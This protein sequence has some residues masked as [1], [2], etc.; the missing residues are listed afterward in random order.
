MRPERLFFLSVFDRVV[1]SDNVDGEPE[2]TL[3]LPSAALLRLVYG[4]LDR[5]HTPAGVHV[6]GRADLDELRQIS[7]AFEVRSHYGGENLD[8]SARAMS[9]KWQPWRWSLTTP[10]AC[11]AA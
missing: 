6:E 2:G 1:L 7:L 3:E 4:R 8:R 10:R 5:R 11:I 9:R